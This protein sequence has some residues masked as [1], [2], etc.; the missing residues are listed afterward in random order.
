[1]GIK[2]CNFFTSWI[3]S[4]KRRGKNRRR[5]EGKETIMG[6]LSCVFSVVVNL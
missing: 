2:R 5:G 1:M 3:L 6:V 4:K